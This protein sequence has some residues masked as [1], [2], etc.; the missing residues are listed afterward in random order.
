M[1]P[2]FPRSG[3][4]RIDDWCMDLVRTLVAVARGEE[5]IHAAGADGL[6][7][8]RSAPNGRPAGVVRVASLHCA[9]ALRSYGG[10]HFH[11]LIAACITLQLCLSVQQDLAIC[12]AL[13]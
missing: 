12:D 10:P 13:S 9:H 2:H 11:F 1:K 3:Q 7:H 8:V 5:A 4:R 6:A